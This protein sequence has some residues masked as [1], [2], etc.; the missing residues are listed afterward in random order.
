LRIYGG[1]FWAKF[2]HFFSKSLDKEAGPAPFAHRFGFA[3]PKKKL[4]GGISKPDSSSKFQNASGL[5]L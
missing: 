3:P 4:F 5:T 1:V 2:E